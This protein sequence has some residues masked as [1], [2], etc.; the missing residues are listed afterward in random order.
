M[1]LFKNLYLIPFSNS[2]VYI[3]G[4]LILI[5]SKISIKKLKLFNNFFILNKNSLFFIYSS[6]INS[7]YSFNASFKKIEFFLNEFFFGS[8]IG[9]S[10][11][12][13]LIGRGYKAYTHINN[14]LFR[15]GYSHNIY[16]TLPFFVKVFSKLKFKKFWIIKSLD[17]LNLSKFIYLIRDFKMPNTYMYKGIYPKNNLIDYNIKSTKIGFL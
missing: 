13:R 1:V 8:F 6:I 11:G 4:N 3:E 5:I 2:F 12:F 15:L 7:L 17:S 10:N 14:F 9:F 16:Y